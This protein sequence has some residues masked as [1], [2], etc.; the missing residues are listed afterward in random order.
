MKKH[1]VFLAALTCVLSVLGLF[2]CNKAP[3]EPIT[4]EGEST[5]FNTDL[6][7]NELKDDCKKVAFAYVYNLTYKT[8]GYV[9]TSTGKV[10]AKVLFFN[11]DVT[12]GTTTVKKGNLYHAVEFSRST[13][14]NFD[15]ER[16]SNDEK[17]AVKRDN[18]DFEVKTL[19]EYHENSYSP[20]QALI[21][22]YIFTEESI[23]SA[24]FLG[25]TD[26]VYAFKYIMDNELAT[27]FVRS[28]MR[29]TGDLSD[30]PTI[31]LATVTIYMKEDFA[32][33]KTEIF[34]EYDAQKPVVGNTACTH[35][36]TITY[37]LSE[38]VTIENQSELLKLLG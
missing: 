5:V 9:L 33:V 14:V 34:A 25:E 28:N 29:A 18:K 21:S 6:T 10:S 23:L 2:A 20:E 15:E 17:I 8:Y 24:E 36:E 22:G 3:I 16:F 35:T 1:S 13:F 12:F 26:G 4:V 37:S 27:P 11:Y 38:N 32:P 30:Y 19:K 31:K 7:V